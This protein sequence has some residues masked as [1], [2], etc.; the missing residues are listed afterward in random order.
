MGSLLFSI[1]F[2]SYVL[3]LMIC[4][5]GRVVKKERP[6]NF[7]GRD[8]LIVLMPVLNSICSLII[9][10]RLGIY[11][12]SNACEAIFYLIILTNLGLCGTMYAL[13]QKH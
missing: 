12:T 5:L 1:G 2:F 11:T 8:C 6:E 13:A 9:L 10:V 4:F 7:D 3:S